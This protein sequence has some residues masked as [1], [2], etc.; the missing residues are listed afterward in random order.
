MDNQVP[1]L[2]ELRLSGV[3]WTGTI[4]R[5]GQGCWGVGRMGVECFE[6][7]SFA[8]TVV[9]FHFSGPSLVTSFRALANQFGLS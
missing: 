1:R 4:C 5:L 3:E 2:C 9:I 6:L 8:V 7:V